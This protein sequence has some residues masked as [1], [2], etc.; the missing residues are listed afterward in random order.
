MWLVYE[1]VALGS[2]DGGGT[3]TSST[4]S[5]IKSERIPVKDFLLAMFGWLVVFAAGAFVWDYFLP[6]ARCCFCWFPWSLLASF[7]GF[8]PILAASTLAD[9]SSD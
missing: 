5:W 9:R 7:F 8:N 1:V 2:S 6:G 3:G 4:S